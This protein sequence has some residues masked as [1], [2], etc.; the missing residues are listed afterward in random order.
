MDDERIE[1]LL[2]GYALPT[3]SRDLDRRVLNDGAAI[4]SHPPEGA[5]LEEVAVA[6]LHQFGFGYLTWAFDF[7][8]TTD[9]EY[10][11]DFI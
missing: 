3:P 4:M 2:K 9:A 5:T 8:T 7:V 6:L 1:R 10:S 11:V